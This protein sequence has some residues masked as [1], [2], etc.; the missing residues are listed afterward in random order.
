MRVDDETLASLNDYAACSFQT[1]PPGMLG[2]SGDVLYDVV[3]ELQ[4]WRRQFP[5]FVYENGSVV[6]RDLDECVPSAHGSNDRTNLPASSTV[7]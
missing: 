5:T 3:R 4:N 6:R 2:V 7:A 1:A